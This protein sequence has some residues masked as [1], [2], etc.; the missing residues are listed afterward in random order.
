MKIISSIPFLFLFLGIWIFPFNYANGQKLNGQ[1]FSFP[2]GKTEWSDT[3]YRRLL[4]KKMKKDGQ[5]PVLM[6]FRYKMIKDTNEGQ[7]YEI[8]IT[9]KSKITKIKFKVT[10]RNNEDIY[11]VRLDPMETKEIQKFYWKVRPGSAAIQ[12]G[13]DDIL[14][15]PNDD[16]LQIRE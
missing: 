2:K 9:N 14:I 6:A 3:I 5:Q 7:W 12:E 8:E 1:S 11:T 16:I 15:A 10:S 4:T 13:D